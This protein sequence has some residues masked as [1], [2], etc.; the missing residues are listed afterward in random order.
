VKYLFFQ[1]ILMV[2]KFKT[3]ESENDVTTFLKGIED[4]QKK[5]DC[6]VLLEI[7]ERLS[8]KPWKIWGKNIIGF[9]KYHYIYASGRE[10]DSMRT[11]FS[12]RLGGISIYIMP[13]YEFWNMQEHLMKLWKY[14]AWKSCLN[15][16]KLSD[17][18]LWI[19]ESIIR[20][21]LDELKTKYPE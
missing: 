5:T 20:L 6:F 2:D 7:F 4:T 21:G 12:A 18:D 17:I 16:K 9:W 8:G 1:Y 15:I 19:L 3:Q 14:K 10:G 13:G 11:G